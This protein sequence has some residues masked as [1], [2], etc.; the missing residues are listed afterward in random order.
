[1]SQRMTEKEIKG[2]QNWAETRMECS[3][4]EWQKQNR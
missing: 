1:M 4:E 2:W 3:L